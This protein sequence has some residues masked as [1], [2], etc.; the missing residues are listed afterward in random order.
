MQQSIHN[1]ADLIQR[2]SQPSYC[3]AWSLLLVMDAR[4]YTMASVTTEGVM[5]MYT[6]HCVLRSPLQLDNICNFITQRA[7]I[8]SC[9]PQFSAAAPPRSHQS[10][11]SV[12][13]KLCLPLSKT[14]SRATNTSG[15]TSQHSG[16][17]HL[18]PPYSKLLATQP[19]LQPSS[20]G[21]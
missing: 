9:R 4:R 3:K 17:V 18:K 1:Q 8:S 21:H 16:R 10:L 2:L 14:C 19:E 7:D 5:W 6:L 12:C 15:Q 13:A 20:Q 11:K